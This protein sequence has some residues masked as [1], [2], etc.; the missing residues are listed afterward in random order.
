MKASAWYAVAYGNPYKPGG[1][2][3][4]VLSF[5]WI[6]G[7]HLLQI[8]EDNP[9]LNEYDLTN[10]IPVTVGHDMINTTRAFLSED[11]I[12][13]FMERIQFK[14]LLESNIN[15]RLQSEGKP[16]MSS[17]EQIGSC[18]TGVFFRSSDINIMT[19]SPLNDVISAVTDMFQITVQ[20]NQIIHRGKPFSF[21]ISSSD[22]KDHSAQV[23]Y[24]R[25]A[26]TSEPLLL[27]F[28]VPIQ[29]WAR[30]QG[31]VRK[32]IFQSGQ[33]SATLLSSILVK[34]AEKQAFFTIKSALTEPM[35]AEQEYNWIT[36]L[37]QSL[38]A[39][40]TGN[41]EII[42]NAGNLLFDFVKFMGFS[43]EAEILAL[44]HSSHCHEPVG[45]EL[46]M[47][48]RG[49]FFKAFHILSQSLS[50]SS[51][52]T[53]IAS[54]EVE[55][56]VQLAAK[57]PNLFKR[58]GPS[59]AVFMEGA[60]VLLFEG[61]RSDLD[62]IGFDLY[63]LRR[64]PQHVSA[65]CFSPILREP[66][67][68]L[69]LDTGSRTY[70]DYF[71]HAVRQFEM[72]KRVGSAS[73]HGNLKMTIKF[74]RLYL[75]NLPKMFLEEG[76]SAT[77]ENTRKALALGYK[78]IGQKSRLFADKDDMSSSGQ[79]KLEPMRMLDE[80]EDSKGEGKS[81]V[82]TPADI[83]KKAEEADGTEAELKS[84]KARIRKKSNLTPM[85]SSFEP[86]VLS[87]SGVRDFIQRFGFRSEAMLSGY[88]VSLTLFNATTEAN[89]DYQVIY[90]EAM[91]FVRLSDR[92]IKWMVIDMKTADPT[93]SN[94]M[95]L[96]LTSRRD[97]ELPEDD[98][99]EM[100]KSIRK[101]IVQTLQN[102]NN[103]PEELPGQQQKDIEVTEKFRDSERL[104][105]RHSHQ[106]KF[107]PTPAT[108][109]AIL[110]ACP[111]LNLSSP[112]KT[113]LTDSLRLR[114]TWVT[115][116]TEHDKATGRFPPANVQEKVEVELDM[117]VDWDQLAQQPGRIQECAVLLYHLGYL[118][119]P[120]TQATQ[121]S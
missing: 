30:A 109:P 99:D 76:L 63:Q 102:D 74:G 73:D 7:E 19:T 98:Q 111:T 47:S 11:Y 68:F 100:I 56:E 31:I 54:A 15:A 85:S 1:L 43:D 29:R 79:F 40:A 45:S 39:I 55:Q 119:K 103:D 77:V 22:G 93:E 57:R 70:N 17:F 71:I 34:F 88:A 121:D 94:D 16:P 69:A 112:M 9:S 95:R 118:V 42:G 114:V 6:V 53:V 3:S 72:A 46:I 105:V 91:K 66:D 92:P 36:S 61:S 86:H 108:L 52:W 48:F 44:V 115:E 104:F 117:V 97:H 67:Q 10:S 23:S 116:Y 82:L 83:I 32:S 87:D 25:S 41:V 101:G 58:L 50:V 5:P 96:A 4:P 26:I 33:I 81:K 2:K 120:Y 78:S 80:E 28:L 27:A 62:P 35:T 12:S 90:D 75:T 110:Q 8:A 84:M 113:L 107:I 106:E 18:S 38:D 59:S 21:T 60:S 14:G 51:L 20:S 13:S 49:H 65:Q 37:Q 24:V 64:R 89:S